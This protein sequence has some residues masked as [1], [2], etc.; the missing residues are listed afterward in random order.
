MIECMRELML[1]GAILCTRGL[2]VNPSGPAGLSVQENRR[3]SAAPGAM[4]RLTPRYRCT[5]SKEG[6]AGRG[7]ASGGRGKIRAVSAGL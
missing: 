2:R 6:L 4:P 1:Q 5:P 3:W 7:G